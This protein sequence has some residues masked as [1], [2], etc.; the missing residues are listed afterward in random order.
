MSEKLH[1]GAWTTDAIGLPCFDLILDDRQAPGASFPHLL[2]TGHISAQADRWGNVNLF[3]TEGGFTWLNSPDSSFARSSLYMMMEIGGELISL[4]HSELTQKE[5]IRI[6]TGY[7]EYLGEV[8]AQGARI[9]VVQ[10]V[11]AMPD[12]RRSINGVFTLTNLGSRRLT[13]R[14]QLRGDVT[15]TRAWAGGHG[16]TGQRPCQTAPG[17]AIFPGLDGLPDGVFLAADAS[18]MPVAHRIT[19]RLEREIILSPGESFTVSCATGYG[20]IKNLSFPSLAD[21]QKAWN[22]QLATFAVDAPETWMKQE[23]L[24]DIGQLLSFKAY[25]SSVAEYYVN[26][27]GYGWAGFGVRE[28]SETSMAL[29][30]GDWELA[31]SSLRFVAKTQLASGDVPKIH[32]MRL[33]RHSSDFESDTEL[34]FVLAA[35][36]CVAQ[37][38]HT[39]FF[40][41]V[42]TYWDDGKGTMWEHLKRAFYWVRDEIGRGT[43]GL[44]LIRD[45]DWNDYLSLVGAEGRGES[46]MNS[47]MACRAF[48]TL[49]TF[50]RQR[51]DSTF[52]AEL[53]SY[54]GEMREAV[55]RAFDEKWFVGGYADTGD[56][57]GS[58]AEDRLFLNAQTWAALGRCGTPEQRRVALKQAVEKCHT[59]I[60]LM[61][62]SRPYSSPAPEHISWCAIPAGD[63][64]NAGIWPQTIYWTVWALAEEGL[65][66]EALDEWKCGTL[67]NHASCFPDVPFGIF[68]GPDCY[69]SGWAGHREGF[70]QVQ[71]LDRARFIPMNPMVAWQAF[72]LQKINQATP[73]P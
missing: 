66:N 17:C 46:V 61:L 12:Q 45:G 9:G 51:G 10:Q 14:L 18:W 71:L 2:S 25:D 23:C 41:E 72:A 33:D 32:T 13:L 16:I 50:A 8:K 48:S 68:N 73:R 63:G 55:T 70:T 43:H 34:W 64:E 65:L 38:G 31:A 7:I 44:V 36:E 30:S 59:S 6:G 3:T 58:V 69:S 52:A 26:L 67:R 40:D 24:W 37:T 54:V 5:K 11:L 29:A 56:A 62:M 21:V 4:L 28:V 19:L 39:D 53:D 1:Y 49:A 22:M 20:S 35:C 57:I 42:C 47:G 60:G 15:P 27:G